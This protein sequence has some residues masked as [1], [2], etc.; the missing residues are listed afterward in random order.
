MGGK[1]KDTPERRAAQRESQRR[2]VARNKEFALAVGRK[3]TKNNGH[4]WRAGK[5]A[6][7]AKVRAALGD[8]YIKARIRDMGWP[9]NTDVP[10]S[11]IN[12]K[13]AHIALLRELNLNNGVIMKRHRESK[14]SK[15]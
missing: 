4:K 8:E 3:N 5:L 6:R 14:K 11:L 9:P 7:A 15:R 12:A 2:W 10:Q 1:H 13:R